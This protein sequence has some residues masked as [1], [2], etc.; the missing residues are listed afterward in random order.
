LDGSNEGRCSQPGDVG[1]CNCE[2]GTL[3]NGQVCTGPNCPAGESV[4]LNCEQ[5]TGEAVAIM[6]TLADAGASIGGA[7]GSTSLTAGAGAGGAGGSSGAGGTSGSGGNSGT[8]GVGGAPPVV[9]PIGT[10]C[11][12]DAD[13]GD[14]LICLEP[15]GSDWFSGGPSDGYC[16][17]NCAADSTVCDA[18][19]ALCVAGQAVDEAYCFESCVRGGGFEKCHARPDTACLEVAAGSA[20]C[21]PS[22]GS[23]S[24][25]PVGEFCD[26]LNGVCV[27]T[28]RVG[29][30][31]GTP[32]SVANDT[33]EGYC[34]DFGNGLVMCT[35]LCTVGLEYPACGV[36]PADAT[37]GDPVCLPVF[38][39]TD[40]VG[41]TGAC[42]QR[43]DCNDQCLH[44]AT[45]CMPFDDPTSEQAFSAL[46]LCLE[47]DLV[48]PNLACGDAGP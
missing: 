1:V 23:D 37:S 2:Q 35:A 10:P 20:A 16:T 28:Q 8:A 30:P 3:V 15:D 29:D 48:S 18:V 21:L 44:P 36:D 45:V 6:V 43:C 33:C 7:G 39:D 11:S 31:I 34:Q 9:Q 25:C 27:T 17:L 5:L 40:G 41:D 13:C 47:D 12:A 42:I 38:A 22:C 19:N 14:G 26:L 4:L 46:G 24:Q 32:C